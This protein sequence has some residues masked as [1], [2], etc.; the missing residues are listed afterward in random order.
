MISLFL[1]VSFISIC[2][3]KEGNT[4]MKTKLA[5]TV[6]NKHEFPVTFSPT[7]LFLKS[8]DFLDVRLEGRKIDSHGAIRCFGD[9][10]SINLDSGQSVTVHLVV[11]DSYHISAPGEYAISVD[12]SELFQDY[13]ILEAHLGPPIIPEGKKGFSIWNKIAIWQKPRRAGLAPSNTIFIQKF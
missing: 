10:E 12:E 11:D 3:S 13:A 8:G 2:S 6:T 4:V 5:Y 1:L 7:G 9:V